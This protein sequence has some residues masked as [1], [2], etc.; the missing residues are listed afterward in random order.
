MKWI[1]VKMSELGVYSN[2]NYKIS[3]ALDHSAM[4]TVT[5]YREGERRIHDIKALGVIWGK[6][7]EFYTPE[8]T[9]HLDDL[10]R[11]FAFNPR[12]GLKIRPF[13]KAHLNR[14]T[15]D[16]LLKL[17]RYLLLIA[18]LPSFEGLEHSKWEKYLREHEKL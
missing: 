8:N 1:D 6:F 11:N 12:N 9:I 10:S 16:E 17:S 15:D 5:M 13:K 14:T 4:F 2:P 7:P 18:K 3:F